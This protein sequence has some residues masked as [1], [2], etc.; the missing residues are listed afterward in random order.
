MVRHPTLIEL[1]QT[2][3]TRVTDIRTSEEGIEMTIQPP[4]ELASKTVLS[5]ANDI[6][7]GERA[8]SYGP[9]EDSFDRIGKLWTIHLSNKLPE[10][11]SVD[12]YDV[13][14]MMTLMKCARA[15]TDVKMDTFVDIAGYAALAPRCAEKAGL[16][17]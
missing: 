12:A 5:T 3:G 11:A 4:A 13:A 10:G 15:Q 14:I 6:I 16:G 7:H 2:E 1:A 17:G 9:A 8:A